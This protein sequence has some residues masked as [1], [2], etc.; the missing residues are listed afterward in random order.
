[1]PKLI[2][3][4]DLCFKLLLSQIIIDENKITA[5]YKGIFLINDTFYLICDLDNGKKSLICQKNIRLQVASI[6]WNEL[7]IK[8]FIK[9]FIFFVL[10]K[11]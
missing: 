5:H 6:V 3:I 10:F 8:K 9:K 7:M 4:K 11:V 1:L 2:I